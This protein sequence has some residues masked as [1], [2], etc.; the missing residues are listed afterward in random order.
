MPVGQ[1]KAPNQAC[2]EGVPLL[3]VLNL[4]NL[5]LNND[6]IPDGLFDFIPNVTIIPA[7][8]K[9]IFP[10]VEPFGKDL[11]AAF[12]ECGNASLAQTY[13]FQQ[14][15]DSTRYTAQQFP[16]FNRFVIKGTYKSSGNGSQVSLGA[17]NIPRGSV[18]V[19]AGGQKLIEGTDYTVDYNLGRVTILNQSVL[20][21]GQAVQIEF[22]NNN[23][24]ATT[25]QSLYGTRLDYK[26]TNKFNIGGTLITLGE[27]PFTQ[28]VQIGDEP[29]HNT[30]F[31]NDI[32]YETNLPWLTKAISKL[33][34]TKEMSILST[35]GEWAYLQPGHSKAINDPN[36]QPQVYIDDFEGTSSGYDLKTP[37]IAW[38]LASTP[39]NSPNASGQIMFP[40]ANLIN[41]ERYGYN[42]ALL[43]WYR[44]D[45]SFFT[46]QTS[47]AA[48]YNTPHNWQNHWVRLVPF[49]EVFP[50]APV[51]TLDQNLY[52]F[53]L[54]FY[55]NQRGPYN[56][57]TTGSKDPNTGQTISYG[58]NTI[59]RI[60]K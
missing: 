2:A 30:I 55:P 22:E 23:Q 5:D 40:E 15:Y 46:Q 53:D 44:I 18:T 11:A 8:G 51:Q 13:T 58:V 35:Y 27:R 1:L 41:D 19:T 16:E 25:T 48:V 20:N 6:P 37:P 45:N 10:V 26:V 57:E 14:L 49:Q 17:G 33:Y 38:H 29:I 43:S 21:S 60:F 3:R 42:R 4:D 9:L 56:Y 34:P 47:P 39:R 32:K 54:A 24:F 7:N 31:G 59:D 52:S 28:K 36:H 50:N 12:A